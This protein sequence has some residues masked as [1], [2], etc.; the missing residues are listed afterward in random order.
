MAG[1]HG[2]ITGVTPGWFTLPQVNVD[3]LS[4]PSEACGV[5]G[6]YSPGEDVARLCYFGLFALQHRGQE[7]AGIAVSNGET[8]TVFKDMGLVAQVFDEA[9]LAPLTGHLGIAHTRYSTTGST[10]WDN[11]QPTYRQVGETSV[12]LAHN[13]NLTNTLALA[14]SLGLDG[15]TDTELMVEAIA[16]HVDDDRSD[17]QGLTRAVLAAL[18]AFEGAFSLVIMDQGNLIGVRDPHGFRPLCLGI[19]PDGGHVLASETAALDIVGADFI[20]EI[21]R[22]E[23]IV[24]SAQGTRSFY[25]FEPAEASLCIFEFV[26]F[27]RPDSRL[28][29]RSVHAS[30]MAMGRTLAV[31]APA[32]GDVIVPVP[33]SGIPAA[34]GYAEVSGIPYVDG[35]VKN[36]YVG[37]T[38]IEPSQ[39]L[40][41]RGIRMKLNPI[42]ASLT[43]RSVVLVDDSIVRGSTTRQLVQMVRDAGAREVHLRI[44][45]PPYRWPCYY[46]MDTT[47]RSLLLA[48]TKTVAEITEFLDVDSLA[49]L[50]LDGLLAAVGGDEESGLCNACLSGEYPTEVPVELSKF[51]ARN[52]RLM[53]TY[54]QAGV[55]IEAGDRLVK[56]IAADV[57]STWSDSVVGNFGGFAAGIEIPAGYRRPVL[58]MSTDGVGTK[59]EVARRA[60]ILSGLGYDLVAMC[61][62]DLAAIGATPLA[63]TDYI[64]TGSID[65]VRDSTLVASISQACRTAGC[66]L[67]GGETAEHP[68]VMEPHHFDLAGAAVGIVERGA[69]IDG[70]KIAPG[71]VMIG[72]S[73]PNLRSNGFS[74]IRAIFDLNDL[75]SPFPGEP[76]RTTGEVLT[77]PSLIYSP[78]IRAVTAGG[79][80]TGLAHVT[81]G[82]LPGNVGRP[83]PPG[84]SAYIDSQ[85]W[86]PP[87]VFKSVQEA[88]KISQEE[89]FATFNMGVGFVIYAEAP[90]VADIIAILVEYGHEGFVIGEVTQ[91]H[92]AVTID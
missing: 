83:L 84:L 73:S 72:V 62:D 32:D 38:F 30:R 52:P 59:I 44:S 65:R 26:Y 24:I 41:D 5:F 29:S 16:R 70:S 35:L 81:G 82:G 63:F 90:A 86:R 14:E 31:E 57:T 49:Y 75:K 60:G 56:A 74:L 51:A 39:M 19:L 47:D 80:V 71:N 92:S 42:P 36:R 23:V 15:V 67:L 21:E 27:A 64:A 48:A 91:G 69:E 28:Y 34:Q 33:E 89:M 13:G 37:R 9:S 11:A 40:R 76:G 22:G 53:S 61:V 50:S 45:S 43:D 7:S 4:K 6:V 25:P 3:D 87:N 78:A 85:M 2:W 1:C 18:P 17:Q 77:E 54:R 8:T 46:G 58:M 68:G 66:A 79:G 12:A 55:D 20:R 10:T 88:G